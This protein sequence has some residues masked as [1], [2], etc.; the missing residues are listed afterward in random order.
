MV[1]LPGPR[2]DAA[3]LE[4]VQDLQVGGVILFARN[5]EAP[6]QVWELTRDLQA[7]ALKASGRPLLIAVDQEG[8]RV[9]RLKTPFALIP[10]ARDLARRGVLEVEAL[11]KKT[12]QELRLVGIN[13]NFAPVLD[14][15]RGPDCPMGDRSY[16]ADPEE[17]ARMGLAAIR[18]YLAGGALPTAKH[19]PGLGDTVADSHEV[20]PLAQSPDPARQ[21]DLLPFRRAVAGGVPLVMTAHLLAPLWDERPA[22]LSAIA[23]NKWLRQEVGF[24]GVIVTD[25]LEMGAIAGRMTAAQGARE[26]L[27]AGADLLLI[28][29]DGQAAWAAAQLVAQDGELSARGLDAAQRLERLRQAVPPGSRGISE[30]VGY[31]RRG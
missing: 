10:P 30:V 1:G 24:N 16:S 3:A 17:V 8:G 6:E 5:I 4:L 20:L 31:F 28:C 13:V 11:A 9:Q 26:A 27:A 21:V 12:A 15:A 7:L 23:L 29:Q 25:D 19:F 2:V 22:T 14:V 18:G